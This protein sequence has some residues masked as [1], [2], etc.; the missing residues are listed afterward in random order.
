MSKIITLIL[1]ISSIISAF[2][3][4]LGNRLKL[5]EYFVNAF[6]MMGTL[7]LSMVGIYSLSPII[8]NILSKLLI[9]IT[10]LIPIDP[11][12]FVGLTF[13][14]DMGGV[15][16]ANIIAE[17][18]EIGLFSGVILS[19]MI[20]ATFVFTLPI[21]VGMIKEAD[22]IFFVK[23]LMYG[24]IT[25]PIGGLVSGL[26][27]K[28]PLLIL[29]VNLL[30]VVIF[31]LLMSWLLYKKPHGIMTIFSF[32]SRAILILSTIGFS[33]GIIDLMLDI[34][35]VE[36]LIPLE[37]GF[38]LVGRITLI[39]SGAYA[40]LSILTKAVKKYFGAINRLLNINSSSLLGLIST[41]TNCVPMFMTYDKMDDRGKVLNAA[42]VVGGGF[43]FG[44]QF[45]YISTVAEPLVSAYMVGKL[46]SG[47]SA[48]FMA[49]II[50]NKQEGIYENK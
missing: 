7:T 31:S 35:V 17:N 40:L 42:F 33:L 27:I 21:A 34:T 23:G 39:L 15:P 38:V 24:L 46:V 47:L 2:D 1:I 14:P 48:I 11:S 29:L 5:G 19:S 45:A 20:G 13:A 37:K 43:V 36:D 3:Y 30:P 49:Y 9:P 25:V 8:G 16:T 50:L 10:K 6:R 28:I 12:I 26:M 4:A 44:G 22:Q 41:L 32:V 18:V